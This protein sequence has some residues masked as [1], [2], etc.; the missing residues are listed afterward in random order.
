MLL[1]L[2]IKSKIIMR[3]TLLTINYF[4]FKN[5]T[6]IYFYTRFVIN[7]SKAVSNIVEKTFSTFKKVKL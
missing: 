5:F 6:S 2:N 4:L 1:F 3:Y 7:T